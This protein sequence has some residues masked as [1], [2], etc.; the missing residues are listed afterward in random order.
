MCPVPY[1]AG[2]FSMAKDPELNALRAEV[3]HL[4]RNA[5]K[6][7]GR[8]RDKGINVRS[9]DPR[10][11]AAL[12]NRYNKTQL[13]SQLERLGNF[14][15][16]T[17][18]FVPGVRGVPIPAAE[19]RKYKAV[20]KKYNLQIEATQAAVGNIRL[21]K[22]SLTI[23]ERY[24]VLVPRTGPSMGG[25]SMRYFPIN[26]SSKGIVS[27][28]GVERLILDTR[29][30]MAPGFQSEQEER[31][32]ENFDKLLKYSNRDDIRKL[33]EQ[34][35]AEE[36]AIIWNFSPVVSTLAENYHSMLAMMSDMDSALE[37]SGIDESFDEIH[38]MLEWA[39]KS[40]QLRNKLKDFESG[41]IA[42]NSTA[43]MYTK[44]PGKVG[45]DRRRK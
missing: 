28:E 21:G 25:G 5:G 43:R 32:R 38:D 34:L 35:T 41:E 16:R 6:K 20:E 19:W 33:A 7:L 39:V 13:K 10:K 24:A 17:N 11:D 31:Q 3:K 30:R 2:H 26:R 18:Q 12:I 9:L 22:S 8:L 37:L 4:Q 15:A 42:N 40:G 44:T 45:K 14:T 36:F 23:A 29:K 27:P 1:G